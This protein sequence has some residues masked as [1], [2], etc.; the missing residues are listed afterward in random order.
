MSTNETQG[1]MLTLEQLKSFIEAAEE[2]GTPVHLVFSCE[3]PELGK[4]HLFYAGNGRFIPFSEHTHKCD[5]DNLDIEETFRTLD[6]YLDVGYS[7]LYQFGC[8]S[9]SLFYCKTL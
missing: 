9:F 8:N 1:N 6:R 2:R 4:I 5:G 7:Y 3:T